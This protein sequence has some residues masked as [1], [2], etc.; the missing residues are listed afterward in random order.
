MIVSTDA[1]QCT[2][3]V[4]FNAVAESCTPPSGSAFPIGS[5]TVTCV[6]GTSQCSFTITVNDSERPTL[7][8]PQNLVVG[9]DASQ[10]S[11]VVN[12]YGV[13]AIDC[14]GTTVSCSPPA[15][16]TFAVGSTS[17]TCTATDPSENVS[18]CTFTVT[19]EDR[20]A[21]TVSTRSGA[22][23]AGKI[24]AKSKGTGPGFYQLLAS[25]NC[26]AAPSIFVKDSLSSTV[27]GPY[28]SGTMIKL[29][30]SSDSNKVLKGTGDVAVHILT[31]GPAEIY[32][33]DA[34]GNVS[35]ALTR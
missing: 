32:A 29:T 15:G 11:A 24:N 19:V 3:T 35:P 28:A 30:P 31:A 6:A 10:C 33:T 1:G 25:D 13:T 20:E 17:V 14:P 7:N 22:N 34:A 4:N 5:T 27:F 16:S 8:C 12:D 18:T 23:P 21:P 2:A 26:D 9:T